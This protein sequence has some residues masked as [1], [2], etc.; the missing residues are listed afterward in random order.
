VLA[1]VC[2][3]PVERLLA[4][5]PFALRVVDRSLQDVRARELGQQCR[6]TDVVRVEVRDDDAFDLQLARMQ[7][8]FPLLTGVWKTQ[9]GID[10]RPGG[11]LCAQRVAVNVIDA[12]RKGER[13]SNDAVVELDD[14]VSVSS[15][16]RPSRL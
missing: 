15:R 4:P 2:D 16:R 13:D 6:S 7:R 8:G 11:V 5:R 3:K 1:H 12:E 10:D 14:V 9:S